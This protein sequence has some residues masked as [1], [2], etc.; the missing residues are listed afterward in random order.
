MLAKVQGQANPELP[1]TWRSSGTGMETAASWVQ[2][3][4]VLLQPLGSP[5]GKGTS[6]MG[7]FESPPA[8]LLAH[9]QEPSCWVPS[10]PRAFLLLS[11]PSSIL[12]CP[13]K[14]LCRYL[15]QLAMQWP[16]CGIEVQSHWSVWWCHKCTFQHVRDTRAYHC[17]QNQALRD[18]GSAALSYPLIHD[19]GHSVLAV[20]LFSISLAWFGGNMI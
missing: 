10:L 14:L 18:Q 13:K 5:G 6:A 17:L 8:I 7:L 12:P 3:Q 2:Q 9:T 1:S 20:V 16:L 19:M 11:L 15:P 4:Q